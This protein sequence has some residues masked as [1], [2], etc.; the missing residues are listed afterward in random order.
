MRAGM[1]TARS[2]LTRNML[3]PVQDAYPAS[4]T[5]TIMSKIPCETPLRMTHQLFMSA[6]AQGGTISHCSRAESTW[7]GDMM[8]GV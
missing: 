7:N 5:C 6:S 4:I 2:A 3:N 1:P 8:F